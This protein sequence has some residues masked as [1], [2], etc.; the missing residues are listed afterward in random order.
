MPE[1]FS[2]ILFQ[3]ATFIGKSPFFLPGENRE[4]DLVQHSCATFQ[5]LPYI[6]FQKLLT[7]L[8]LSSFPFFFYP[9]FSLFFNGSLNS[10]SFSFCPGFSTI[11]L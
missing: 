11:L 5:L 10:L 8:K 7:F 9:I 1:H 2:V 4:G 3:E 6:F